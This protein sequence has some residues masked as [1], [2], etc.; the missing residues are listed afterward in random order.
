MAKTKNRRRRKHRGSQTGRVDRGGRGSR[1]RNRQQAKA[2]ARARQLA[3][4]DQPPSWGGAFRRGLL[5][6]GVFLA[7]VVLAFRQPIGNSLGL[8]AFMLAIYVPM[9]YFFDGMVWRRR[10][11]NRKRAGQGDTR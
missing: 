8:G 11:R 3:K 1:P 7:V 10:M 9:G 4:R 6:A 2:Q 5:A